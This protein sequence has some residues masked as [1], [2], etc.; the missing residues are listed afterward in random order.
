MATLAKEE[1]YWTDEARRDFKEWMWHVNRELRRTIGT[2]A[3]FLPD[4]DYV[5]CYRMHETA[6]DTAKLAAAYAASE[7]GEVLVE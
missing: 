6:E 3:T 2:S 7:F 1:W 5:A 4:F